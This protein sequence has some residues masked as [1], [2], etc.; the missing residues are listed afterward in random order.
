MQ[1]KKY[2]RIDVVCD[3]NEHD[4]DMRPLLWVA[5]VPLSFT[6]AVVSSCPATRPLVSPMSIQSACRAAEASARRWTLLYWRVVAGPLTSQITSQEM[7]HTVPISNNVSSRSTHQL[8]EAEDGWQH[9]SIQGAK[10]Q[11]EWFCWIAQILFA[12]C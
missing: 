10:Q 5:N 4:D 8:Q 2:S 3:S 7:D 1:L 11:R 9:C 12:W 6:V